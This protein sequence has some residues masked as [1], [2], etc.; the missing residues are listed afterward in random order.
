[1]DRNHFLDKPI[2]NLDSANEKLMSVHIRPARPG[3][4]STAPLPHPQ[5]R[6]GGRSNSTLVTGKVGDPR[7]GYCTGPCR[8]ALL[9]TRCRGPFT[10][11]QPG[12]LRTDSE[13]LGR[14]WTFLQSHGHSG[15][16]LQLRIG[17]CRCKYTAS[18]IYISFIL[19]CFSL[20]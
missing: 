8:W 9:G 3:I 5:G 18:G 1:M 14:A 12:V 13:G 11:R 4:R 15:D 10:V 16:V 7:P 2:R 6:S 20:F 17:E 19:K